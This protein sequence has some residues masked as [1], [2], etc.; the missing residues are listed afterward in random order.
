MLAP[1]LCLLLL[2][3]SIKPT[4]DLLCVA[5]ALQAGEHRRCCSGWALCCGGGGPQRAATP[6]RARPGGG[7][8]A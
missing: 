1:C 8:T 6:Q 3:A 5:L 7:P 2:G 4:I